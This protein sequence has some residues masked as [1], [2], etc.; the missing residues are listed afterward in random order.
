MYK[1]FCSTLITLFLLNACSSGSEET[2][3]EEAPLEKQAK[4]EN[5]IHIDINGEE[6]NIDGEELEKKL[7]AGFK[8]MAEEL[9]ASFE[10]AGQNMD[11][12]EDIEMMDHKE[13]KA[14]LPSRIG[15]MTQTEHSSENA[16]SFGFNVASAEAKYEFG[17]K[18]IKLTVVDLGGVPMAMFGLSFWNNIEVDK[19][20]KEEIEKVYEENGHKYHVKYNKKLEQGE[21][22][23]VVNDRYVIKSEGEKVNL[24][25]LKSAYSK[26]NL[27]KLK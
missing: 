3:L 12:A 2:R 9:S 19:E 7:S 11:K 25:A 10:E 18:W 17:E 14:L 13:L 22:T 21:F 6:I 16:G 4:S 20:T 26:V 8:K 15:W 5:D 1:L 24:N 23:T 27:G